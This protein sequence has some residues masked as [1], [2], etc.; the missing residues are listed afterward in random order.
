LVEEG[1]E[2]QIGTYA[3][4]LQPCFAEYGSLERGN[5]TFSTKAFKNTLALPSY[6]Y[7]KREDQEYICSKLKRFL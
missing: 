7:M 2:T 5:L 4:H 1:I 3:L 6:D